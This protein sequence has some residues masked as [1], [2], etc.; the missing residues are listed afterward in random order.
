MSTIDVGLLLNGV[1][2]ASTRCAESPLRVVLMEG[3]ALKLPRG[4]ILL[5][6]LSGT[7]WVS[8]DGLD[9]FLQAGDRFRPVAGS[10]PA[11]VSPLGTLP[12]LV[13]M[14]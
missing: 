4:S 1:S 14:R 11:V 5:R 13:E 8:Q 2:R 7:A 3:E 12:L 9:T 10:D 6:I